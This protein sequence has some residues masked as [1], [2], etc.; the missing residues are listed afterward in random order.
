MKQQTTLQ[1][2]TKHKQHPIFYNTEK[3]TSVCTN[4]IQQRQRGILLQEN[5]SPCKNWKFIQC[6][7][8]D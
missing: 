4:A 5:F 3:H 2:I 8:D 6:E 7:V 1:T